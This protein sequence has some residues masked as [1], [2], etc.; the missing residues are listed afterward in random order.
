MAEN[1]VQGTSEARDN[2]QS[3]DSEGYGDRSAP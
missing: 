3:Q 1:P 2:R